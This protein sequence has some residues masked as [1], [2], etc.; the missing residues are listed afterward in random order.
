MYTQNFQNFMYAH[1]MWSSPQFNI[2]GNYASLGAAGGVMADC[3]QTNTTLAIQTA[4]YNDIKF[5]MS[6]ERNLTIWVAAKLGNADAVSVLQNHWFGGMY[7]L[8]ADSCTV[9]TILNGT[10]S[11]FTTMAASI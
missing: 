7:R 8:N 6:T 9:N 3:N 11:V 1:L 10:N 4:V 2:T 5:G